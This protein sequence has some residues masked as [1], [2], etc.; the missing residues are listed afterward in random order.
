[1]ASHWK[2]AP[3]HQRPHGL[4]AQKRRSKA[5][6]PFATLPTAGGSSCPKRLRHYEALTSWRREFCGVGQV[7][8]G[9]E[10][11]IP[12]TAGH[13]AIASTPTGN[14]FQC[15]DGRV[16]P[17]GNRL[18]REGCVGR[19]RCA[20]LSCYG[21]LPRPPRS[22]S[23]TVGLLLLDRFGY[24]F[25]LSNRLIQLYVRRLTGALCEFA[26]ERS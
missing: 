5:A 3:R 1:M 11:A 15:L 19:R 16:W 26:I 24:G 9:V 2:R 4:H 22:S 10:H 18:L 25:Y 23:L 14:R 7:W 21:P 8:C 17:A 12:A 13:H 20:K 6:E